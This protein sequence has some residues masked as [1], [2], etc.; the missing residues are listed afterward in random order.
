MS[1]NVKVLSQ[2]EIDAGNTKKQQ[3]R[4]LVSNVYDIQKLRIAA[5][6]RLVQSF[7]AQL[8]VE[9][10]RKMRPIKDATAHTFQEP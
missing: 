1:E 4:A 10:S 6:N 9:P 8:G 3:I 5:G 7:Y 2:E